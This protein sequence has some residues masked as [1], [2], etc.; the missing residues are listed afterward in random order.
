MKH[1][2]TYQD[3]FRLKGPLVGYTYS[4]TMPVYTGV[5]VISDLFTLGTNIEYNNPYL[6]NYGVDFYKY[7]DFVIDGATASYDTFITKLPELGIL[8]PYYTNLPIEYDLVNPNPNIWRVQ[9][10][11]WHSQSGALFCEGNGEIDFIMP[12][13]DYTGY[14]YSNDGIDYSI[15]FTVQCSSGAILNIGTTAYQFRGEGLSPTATTFYHDDGDQ[16]R[17]I[18]TGDTTA[19]YGNNEYKNFPTQSYILHMLLNVTSSG[20]G[21]GYYNSNISNDS[22]DSS[23]NYSAFGL[24][25]WKL[26]HANGDYRPLASTFKWDT[27]ISK[28]GNPL[29]FI[30]SSGIAA[31]RHIEYL[32]VEP[33]PRYYPPVSYDTQYIGRFVQTTTPEYGTIISYDTDIGFDYPYSVDHTNLCAPLIYGYRLSSIDNL[34]GNPYCTIRSTFSSGTLSGGNGLY[35]LTIDG[36]T[37]YDT[38]DDVSRCPDFGSQHF[39]PN[40]GASTTINKYSVWK[41]GLSPEFVQ[42]STSNKIDFPWLFGP[43]YAYI[44]GDGSIQTVHNRFPSYTDYDDDSNYY[45]TIAYA[46]IQVVSNNVL[47]G[48][49]ASNPTNY[50][51]LRVYDDFPI[52]FEDQEPLQNLFP[53]GLNAVWQP[54]H[55]TPYQLYAIKNRTFFDL[56][57]FTF[58]IDDYDTNYGHDLLR[59]TPTGEYFRAYTKPNIANQTTHNAPG[60]HEFKEHIYKLDRNN[61]SDKTWYVDVY[62]K[63]QIASSGAVVANNNLSICTVG[64]NTV[65]GFSV[66]DARMASSGSLLHGFYPENQMYTK[67]PTWDDPYFYVMS[68]GLAPYDYWEY[69]TKYHSDGHD[70][71]SLY[72][73]FDMSVVQS[74]WFIYYH[75]GQLLAT[76]GTMTTTYSGGYNCAPNRVDS[77]ITSGVLVDAFQLNFGAS[78]DYTLYGGPRDPVVMFGSSCINSC[79]NPNW[80][81]APGTTYNLVTSSYPYETEA[82]SGSITFL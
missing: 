5:P 73:D 56:D 42:T 36:C 61:W 32:K 30:V 51:L 9:S 10:G 13:P 34:Q 77:I 75:N 20:Y 17:L 12:P 59:I 3:N 69:G 80:I 7:G 11:N 66:Y 22:A 4:N 67:R 21:I 76:S 63:I 46:F 57:E 38:T 70:K 24:E 31:L 72:D 44:S 14:G 16:Y 62:G 40:S 54:S 41:G 2:F 33:D 19:P 28:L 74:Q 6:I 25:D 49:R 47:V 71:L 23:Y 48:Y 39:I 78:E 26:F 50:Y 52:S 55:T 37:P 82:V 60:Y 35:G 15:Y 8:S 18:K 43:Q 79:R 58:S 45:F 65:D 81:T 29:T 1:A 68:S 53:Y 64:Y 27:D